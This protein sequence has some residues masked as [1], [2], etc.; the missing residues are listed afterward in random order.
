[1]V[2]WK[3]SSIQLISTIA[4]SSLFLFG[5]TTFYTDY[6]QKP[7]IEVNF[8]EPGCYNVQINSTS[9]LILCR[10]QTNIINVG[11]AA[12]TG[13]LLTFELLDLPFVH[14]YVIEYEPIPTFSTVLDASS[15]ENFTWKRAESNLLS[16]EIPRLAPGSTFE[17][18]V[19]IRSADPNVVLTSSPCGSALFS[20]DMQ[21]SFDSL[22]PSYKISTASDQGT[23]IAYGYTAP[24]D[25]SRNITLFMDVIPSFT[26]LIALS[27]VSAVIIFMPRISDIIRRRRH[28]NEQIKMF[29]SLL[30]EVK[31]VH[32]TLREDVNSKRIFPCKLWGSA[33]S[34][35]KR[36]L[37]D[38]YDDYNSVNSF[39]EV[40]EIRNSLLAANSDAFSFSNRELLQ[41]SDD[42]LR[43]IRWAKYEA[44]HFS[45]PIALTI[46]GALAVFAAEL[47]ILIL[48]SPDDVQDFLVDV[49]RY[50]G[51]PVILYSVMMIAGAVI[52]SALLGKILNIQ[53]IFSKRKGNRF[54]LTLSR[55]MKIRLF[56][57]SL[58][59]GGLP[60]L[61]IQLSREGFFFASWEFVYSLLLFGI[62]EIVA[63]FLLVIYAARKIKK[64]V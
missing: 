17:M 25:Y 34:D 5:V 47:V 53:S 6:L 2:D 26:P 60:V 62:I 58:I 22:C 1:V 29:I 54:K 15:E 20:A 7:Q 33:S 8:S 50:Q 36:E 13:V 4:G 63:M 61:F 24:D 32:D 59:L 48:S 12:A 45:V 40:L 35:V 37:F 38:N 64:I 28:G 49:L 23:K 27:A 42:I 30:S 10:V 19:V 44:I 55:T 51:I 3:S 57:L 31:M 11:N 43:K 39:Y 9:T 41:I 46:F 56:V 16:W 52:A 21:Q 18:H 14:S